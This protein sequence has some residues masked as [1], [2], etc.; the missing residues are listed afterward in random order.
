MRL[1]LLYYGPHK[2][3]FTWGMSRRWRPG[4]SRH[5]PGPQCTSSVSCWAASTKYQSSHHHHHSKCQSLSFP[6]CFLNVS[7]FDVWFDE[8]Q[9]N[10][11]K[12]WKYILFSPHHLAVLLTQAVDHETRLQGARNVCQFIVKLRVI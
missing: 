9:K 4:C 2:L 11:P 8:N 6:I 1:K 7:T 10:N 5:C 12:S 3:F